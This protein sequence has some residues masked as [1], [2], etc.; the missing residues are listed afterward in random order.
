MSGG[1]R[2]AEA[3]TRPSTSTNRPRSGS[4]SGGNAA[5]ESSPTKG[6]KAKEK[7]R[8]R[9]DDTTNA[10][11][12]A[13]EEARAEAEGLEA[14]VEDSITPS[15]ESPPMRNGSERTRTLEHNHAIQNAERAKERA[16]KLEAEVETLKARLQASEKKR[17]EP[18]AAVA[19]TT[20]PQR[21]AK[22]P[23]AVSRKKQVMTSFDIF[24]F[25]VANLTYVLCA[26]IEQRS[27]SDRLMELL[28]DQGI[29]RK[30]QS[31]VVSR[32]IVLLGM[33]WS[34]SLHRAQI[35]PIVQSI[36]VQDALGGIDSDAK[37][38]ELK[39]ASVKGDFHML[40]HIQHAQNKTAKNYRDRIQ[41]LVMALFEESFDPM[42]NEIKSELFGVKDGDPIVPDGHHVL[43]QLRALPY[44]M[45]NGMYP[46]P[47][48]TQLPPPQ[49]PSP[50]ARQPA[51]LLARTPVHAHAFTPHPPITPPPSPSAGWDETDF[52]AHLPL[53]LFPPLLPS[54]LSYLN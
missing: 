26:Q 16:E 3:T 27:G 11:T 46:S 15:S 14:A 40:Q 20:T 49:R 21:K 35:S 25:H 54:P 31:R 41:E 19:V 29:S 12:E 37:Y 4:G 50:P 5:V 44:P 52:K 23:A 45:H 7:P 30:I 6:K 1:R 42:V 34:S 2:K 32:L 24:K 33:R 53:P 43:V 48:T 10:R 22:V 39:A 47:P 13:L 28:A 38:K 8:A 18:E 51:L 17:K 9:D 36:V